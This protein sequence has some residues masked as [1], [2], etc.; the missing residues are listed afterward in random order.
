MQK[1]WGTAWARFKNPRESKEG[2]SQ[3]GKEHLQE[4]PANLLHFFLLALRCKRADDVELVE[5]GMAAESQA[6]LG[7][8]L[9][10]VSSVPGPVHL[11]E[12]RAGGFR[13][14]EHRRFE[15]GRPGSIR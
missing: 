10:A 2:L 8:S 14:D 13:L 15:F 3:F 5:G 1:D 9:P 11:Q 6:W 12:F 7:R 4:A